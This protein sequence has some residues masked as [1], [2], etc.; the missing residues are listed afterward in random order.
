M[1]SLHGYVLLFSW[2]DAWQWNNQIIWQQHVKL[3]KKLSSCFK[4]SA[5]FAFSLGVPAKSTALPTIWSF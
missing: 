1:H 5:V 2:V 4:V 3:L